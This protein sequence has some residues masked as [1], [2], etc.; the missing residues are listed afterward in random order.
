MTGLDKYEDGGVHPYMS[1]SRSAFW[2]FNRN[3]R[4]SASAAVRILR[5]SLVFLGREGWVTKALGLASAKG[6][7]LCVPVGRGD[8]GYSME[9]VKRG[10]Q[11]EQGRRRP[12]AMQSR[13]EPA[14]LLPNIL[15]KKTMRQLVAVT[16]NAFSL[17]IAV[18]LLLFF[19]GFRESDSPG[20]IYQL[21]K[22]ELSL[23]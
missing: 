6:R 9:P 23:Q 11:L 14:V 18:K 3:L 16:I 4:S 12:R 8:G 19:A 13:I 10:R 20:D 22:T 17:F 7:S 21:R 15:L 5:V 2:T 1:Y